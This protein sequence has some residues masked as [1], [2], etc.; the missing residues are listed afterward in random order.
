MVSSIGSEQYF[1]H[2]KTSFTRDNDQRSPEV[3][4]SGDPKEGA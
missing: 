2:K 3:R 4:R 1:K